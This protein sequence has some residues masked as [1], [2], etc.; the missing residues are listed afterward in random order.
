MWLRKL[1]NYLRLFA[2]LL[3]AGNPGFSQVDSLTNL[4]GVELE[5][6]FV[7]SVGPLKIRYWH[8]RVGP[9]VAFENLGFW[10]DIVPFEVEDESLGTINF[11]VTHHRNRH[12]INTKIGFWKEKSSDDLM[13]FI[14]TKWVFEWGYGYNILMSDPWVISV[15]TS[16]RL[17]R[18][19]FKSYDRIA[20]TIDDFLN[21]REI[22]LAAHPWNVIFGVNSTLYERGRYSAEGYVGYSINLNQVVDIKTPHYIVSSSENP[23][24]HWVLGITIGY[25]LDASWV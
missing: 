5:E 4:Y 19:G 11:S 23:L 25:W 20:P 14:Q 13:N 12:F 21:T 6:V 10:D 1:L 15:F 3:F 17:N 8:F 24:K 2:L 22:R 16:L 7:D 18:F 9:D